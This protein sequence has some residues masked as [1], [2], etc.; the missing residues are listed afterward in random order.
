MNIYDLEYLEI[1][2]DSM[3]LLQGGVYTNAYART[4]AGYQRGSASA[5]ASA[6]GDNTYTNAQTATNVHNSEFYSTTTSLATGY[7]YA[8]SGNDT[9]SSYANSQSWGLYAW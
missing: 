2:S 6:N 9:S 3:K 8:N 7:G 1:C 5:S 4:H